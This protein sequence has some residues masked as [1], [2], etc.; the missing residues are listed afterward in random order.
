LSVIP[1][2]AFG[3]L[4]NHR[5]RGDRTP[6]AR[7]ARVAQGIILATC[8]LFLLFLVGI[9]PWLMSLVGPR[10]GIPILYQIVL[11]LGVFSAVLTL[12]ALIAT[13]LAWKNGYWGV[14]RRGYYTAL[15]LAAVAFVWFLNF[16]NLLGWRF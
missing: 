2:A 1:V 12:G 13:V 8:V 4:R 9:L 5:P 14:V 16:W 3:A 10:F 6:P 11:G 15:T 7:G